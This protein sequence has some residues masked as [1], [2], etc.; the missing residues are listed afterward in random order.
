MLLHFIGLQ[1]IVPFTL[2]IMSDVAQ[3]AFL[4]VQRFSTD[5]HA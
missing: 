1:A 2:R 3:N 5:W 4:R